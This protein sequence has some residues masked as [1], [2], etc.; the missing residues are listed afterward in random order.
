MVDILQ[1][2]RRPQAVLVQ[3]AITCV[4]GCKDCG[5]WSCLQAIADQPKLAPYSLK[6]VYKVQ[7]PSSEL[8]ELSVDDL[9]NCM[10]MERE[11]V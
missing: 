6:H 4:T 1:V 5:K 2:R 9:L 8:V 3:C 10:A 7:S 11:I